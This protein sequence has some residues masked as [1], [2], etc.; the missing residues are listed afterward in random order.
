VAQAIAMDYFLSL[1]EFPPQ[2]RPASFNPDVILQ[3]IESSNN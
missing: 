1:K 2:Q 3:K